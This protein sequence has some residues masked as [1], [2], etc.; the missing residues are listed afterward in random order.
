MVDEKSRFIYYSSDL[1]ENENAFITNVYP[2]PS[3]RCVYIIHVRR[4]NTIY[5]NERVE[6]FSFIR[7]SGRRRRRR[8][9]SFEN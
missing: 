7:N 9:S 1:S 5:Y 4:T 3:V 8:V 6:L 2:P